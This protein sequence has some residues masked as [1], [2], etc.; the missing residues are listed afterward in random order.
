MSAHSTDSTENRR[1]YSYNMVYENEISTAHFFY[2]L[3]LIDLEPEDHIK[4]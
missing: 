4:I 3:C 2:S 1:N